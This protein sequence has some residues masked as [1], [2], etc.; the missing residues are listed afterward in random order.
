MSTRTPVPHQDTDLAHDRDP[1]QR[2]LGDRS[3][4]GLG[5]R[6]EAPVRAA[7]G[8]AWTLVARR[9]VMVKLTDKSFLIGTAVTLALIVGALALQ[10]V[11]SGHTSTSKIAAS[12]PAAVTMVEK[13]ADQA[14]ALDD[15]VKVELV[16]S[17]SDTAAKSAVEDEDADAWLRQTASG[18]ELTTRESADSSLLTVVQQVVRADTI[19]RN[20]DAAGTTLTALEQGS[21]VAT[22]QLVGDA[23]KS[24]LSD[25]MGFAFAFLF[26]IAALTFGI[27]LA[28]SVVEEKQSR[29]V[30]II[31]GAIPLRQLLAGKI[32]GNTVLAVG[33][34]AIYV[35]VALVGLAFTDYSG[36][37][38]GVS[39]TVGW[40]LAF[41]LA[42]FVALSC[43]WAV[44]GA[45]ASRTEDLQSTQTPV[46]MLVMLMFFGG[47]FL[48]GTVRTVASFFPP[49]SA[50]L[51]PIR[52]LDGGVAWWEP[53]VA[54][55][56][57]VGFAA[58]LVLAGERIYRRALMQTGGKL[59]LK[60][61]WRLEE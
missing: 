61:A 51:M 3:Q 14:P 37:I 21:Q 58:V 17:S 50:L 23:K 10:V 8:S 4:R 42:G 24:Q 20:A 25:L 49:V 19:D 41:F 13:L 5:D 52:M 28:S 54:M 27:T 56:L 15:S 43:L 1:S 9:E 16:R 6:H 38:A 44:A 48:D 39:G 32:A 40:F 22:T 60:E 30:E 34:M 12:S 55:V 18:W 57:L 35:G 59:S 46:T 11:L 26:Y 45:L 33:Q 47:L 29:I 31:A 7:G 53:L 2:G 36:L